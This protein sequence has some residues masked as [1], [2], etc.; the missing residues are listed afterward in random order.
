MNPLPSVRWIIRKF[1][2]LEVFAVALYR[3][4]A[5]FVRPPL[6]PIFRHFIAIEKEHRTRFRVLDRKFKAGGL[7]LAPF[8]DLFGTGLALIGSAFGE[9]AILT[10]E[11]NVELKAIADYQDAMNTVSHAEIRTTIQT[12]LNDEKHHD[13]LFDLLEK[14][15]NDER[16]HVKEL[17][18]ALQ[19]HARS[20]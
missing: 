3:T 12:V 16:V 18:H 20:R 15:C 13:A 9:R 2:L 10:M 6:K 7:W 5:K 8:I 19:E 14:F 17:A 11:R 1:Y 4:H